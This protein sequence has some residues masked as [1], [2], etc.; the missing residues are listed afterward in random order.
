METG[1]A[2]GTAAVRRAAQ[3]KGC[4]RADDST[5]SHGRSPARRVEQGE[6]EHDGSHGS[7]NG[8]FHKAH[9]RRK[10]YFYKGQL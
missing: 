6:P 5:M 10:S 1:A 3:D 8:T 9:S 4:Y 2:A 7:T